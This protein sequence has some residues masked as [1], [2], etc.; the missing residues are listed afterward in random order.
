MA[1]PA[2][3]PPTLHDEGKEACRMCNN[4]GGCLAET[5]NS[6][7][8]V[9]R[10]VRGRVQRVKCDNC[11]GRARCPVCKHKTGGCPPLPGSGD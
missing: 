3:K 11:K 2:R 1:K 9:L 8:Q 6:E 5:C 10:H 7:G 4:K